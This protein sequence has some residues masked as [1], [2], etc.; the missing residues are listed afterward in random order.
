MRRFLSYSPSRTTSSLRTGARWR[1]RL[2]VEELECRTV[3]SVFTPAQISH[4]YGFD[5]IAF[6]ANGKTVPGDGSGQTIA[7]VTAYDDAHIQSDLHHF[8]G[9]FNLPDP[10]F[11]KATPQGLPAANAGWSL[12]TALDVEWAHA[13][14][15]KANILL[16]EAASAS[17]NDLIGAVDYAR[18]QTGVVAVSMSW[19]GDEFANE[20]AFDKYFTTPAGHLGGSSGLAGSANLP[21]GITFIASAGDSPGTLWPS[22]SPNVV[23]VGGTSLKVLTSSGTYGSETPWSH[24]G[25]GIS[26]FE[27][28]PAYQRSVQNSG[29]RTTPDVAYDANPNT[30]VYVYNS[31]NGGSWYA[32]GGTSAGAPQWAGLV[33]IANQGRA[34]AGKGSLDGSSQ[35]LYALYT[36][37]QSGSTGFNSIATTGSS[38]NLTTGLGSPQANR[39]AQTLVNVTGHGVTVTITA[40]T[41][42]TTATATPG[43]VQPKK[44][45]P[46]P[47][48]TPQA[49]S[50][51]DKDTTSTSSNTS[52]TVL[53]IV[54]RP[55]TLFFTGNPNVHINVD[56]TV[57]LPPVDQSAAPRQSTSTSLFQNTI[58]QGSGGGD[59]SLLGSDQDN[60][61]TGPARVPAAPPDSTP[62]TP[63]KAPMQPTPDGTSA[64]YGG[65]RRASDAYFTDGYLWGEDVDD[66]L[67]QAAL[68]GAGS[69]LEPG[70]A[71]AALALLLGGCWRQRTTI[72]PETEKQPRLGRQ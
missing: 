16:V 46:T 40:P 51:G 68:A 49:T 32:V 47:S 54:P 41:T 12:E 20:A 22:V 28:E 34:L 61:N 14:A 17:L 71:A 2:R 5:Q 72:A 35:T 13:V 53:V 50:D 3:L 69:V 25:G 10:N 57:T 70:A 52:V 44:P 18:H 58:G 29:Q 27:Q 26:A 48:S 62:G 56:P 38:Y 11:T 1:S 7:I 19:G 15:P 36:V 24:S 4:A 8:D 59:N 31:V 33:A 63:P 64:N 23:A 6:S 60:T 55:S 67:A 39:L 43:P 65:R 45:A 37:A 21:G 30:G 42:T 66:S 9:A